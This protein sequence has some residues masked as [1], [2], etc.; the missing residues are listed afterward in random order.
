MEDVSFAIVAV[1]AKLFN[2]IKICI[3]LQWTQ[4]DLNS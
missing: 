1:H 4:G 3:Y 2:I